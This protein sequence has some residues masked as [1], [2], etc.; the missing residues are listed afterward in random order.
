MAIALL[1]VRLARSSR[2]CIFSKSANLFA[3]FVLEALVYM[4]RLAG[5]RGELLPLKIDLI[6]LPVEDRKI[7]PYRYSDSWLYFYRAT[8]SDL[9]RPGYFLRSEDFSVG[10][11][12]RGGAFFLVRPQGVEAAS[13]SHSICQQL[14]GRINAPIILKKIEGS[15]AAQLLASG[16]FALAKQYSETLPLEDEA[17]PEQALRLDRLFAADGSIQREA[18]SFS[19]RVRRFKQKYGPIESVAIGSFGDCR[20]IRRDIVGFLEKQDGKGGAYCAMAL[21]TLRSQNAKIISSLYY[22]P[23]IEVEGLYISEVFRDGVA[24]LYCALSSRSKSGIT[25]WMDASFFGK[26]KHLG[27]RY[28]LLGGAETQGV[29]EYIAK[30]LPESIPHPMMQMIYKPL[31]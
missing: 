16:S 15:I 25:E 27:V 23:K 28:L 24:G 29:C 19:R 12:F 8:R 14:S 26:L 30:L 9:G 11:G 18:Y 4:L 7:L 22:G 20:R 17:F 13:C 6:N 10:I 31:R 2:T 5:L 21:A 1:Q 3:F